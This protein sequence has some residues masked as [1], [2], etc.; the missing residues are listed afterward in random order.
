MFHLLVSFLDFKVTEECLFWL[1]RFKTPQ[2]QVR[3]ERKHRS[4]G[5]RKEC[6]DLDT[7]IWP[8]DKSLRIKVKDTNFTG[9]PL[10]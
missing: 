1:L 3:M 8:S 10:N 4:K 5:I 2:K 7:E 9:D 6:I